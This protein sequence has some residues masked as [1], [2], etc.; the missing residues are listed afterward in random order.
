MLDEPTYGLDS[1]HRQ[2]LL[3]RIANLDV[4]RQILL[5]TH[6]AMGDVLGHRIQVFRKDR[7]T[8]V[9]DTSGGANP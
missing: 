2:A 6:Q 8:V 9:A 4:S 1:A 5:V 7:E 3:N